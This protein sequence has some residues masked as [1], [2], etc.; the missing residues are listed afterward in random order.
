MQDYDYQ[1]VEA[2]LVEAR[3]WE[4]HAR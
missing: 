3:R 2:C 4:L 1:R